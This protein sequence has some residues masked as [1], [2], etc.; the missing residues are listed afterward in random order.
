MNVYVVENPLKLRR[1]SALRGKKILNAA[2]YPQKHFANVVKY[3]T[4][5]LS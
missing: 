1:K 4:R 5:L 2:K 3:T